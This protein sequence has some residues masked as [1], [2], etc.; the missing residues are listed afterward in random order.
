MDG[1]S[2]CEKKNGMHGAEMLQRGYY[3]RKEK[4]RMDVYNILERDALN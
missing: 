4:K 2:G 1:T 3:G